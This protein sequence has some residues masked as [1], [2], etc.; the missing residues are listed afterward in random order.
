MNQTKV[1]KLTV[2]A[3]SVFKLNGQLIEWG[4]NFSQ[5]HGLTSARWQ[6]LGAISMA[7]HPPNVPQIAKAMGVTRQGVL[8]QINLLVNEGLVESLPNPTHKRSPLYAMTAKG[9]ATYEAL[10]E[11]WQQHLQKVES[12]FTVSDLD[13]VLRV[14]SVMSQVYADES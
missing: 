9:Q 11:R 1:D 7:P 5:P 6:V 12:A 14:L 8:K 4:N 3:L 2:I 10:I 13:A